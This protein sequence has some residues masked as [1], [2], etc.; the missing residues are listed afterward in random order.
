MVY[1]AKAAG[2]HTMTHCEGGQGLLNALEAGIDT[3]EHGFY[4]T[5][6]DVERM[7]AQGTYLVPTLNCNYGILKVIERDPDA[8]IHEQS[9]VVARQIIADHKASIQRAH[10]AGVKIAMG[11]DAFGWDQGDSLH[12]LM[13]LVDAGMSPMEAIVA[14]T[15]TGAE[16]LG[17]EDRLG[18][19]APGKLAD[20]LIV[21]GDP[22]ADISLLRNKDNLRLIMQGGVVHKNTLAD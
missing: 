2:K 20:L 15:R 13:L 17:Q 11:A 3:I 8:G 18:T 12:E 7:A 6:S 22:L 9:V 16:L 4:L 5:E 10:Q 19:I 21:E 1:E 14:G